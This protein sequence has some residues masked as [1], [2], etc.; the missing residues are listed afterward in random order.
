MIP[1]ANI[2]EWRAVVPWADDAQVEQDLV[3]SRAIVELFSAV[4]L[5]KRFAM[6]GGTVLN[7][8]FLKPAAR[9]SEDIDLVQIASGAIGKDLEQI[10][11]KLDSWLGKPDV[12]R[13]Q[14]S[15]RLSYQ[16]ESEIEP[17]RRLRLKLEINTR[18]HFAL[19]GFKRIP[20]S[21]VNT[22]FSGACQVTTYDL[23][24]LLGTKLRALF[25]RRKGRDLFDLWVC[26]D[27]G[28]V[29]PQSVVDCCV[30]YMRRQGHQVSRAEFVTN[31]S[32]KEQHPG[33][34]GDIMPLKLAD[35]PYDPA[36][37]IHIVTQQLINLWPAG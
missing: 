33:F 4:E 14:S 20:F 3:L 21:V 15:V 1:Q 16:F 34:L 26:L 2:T 28:M 32:A 11:A 7:K 35:V 25:Q 30:E 5:S 37:A 31:L 23:D 12:T 6:R 13:G 10:R 22:W 27:R 17:V 24:E 9:Y 29:N 8:L 36:Q 19:K 18:E